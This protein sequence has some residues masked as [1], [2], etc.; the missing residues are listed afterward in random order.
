MKLSVKTWF[1]ISS[2]VI[3]MGILLTLGFLVGKRS[4]K[5]VS[6]ST[7]YVTDTVYLDKPF[8][9]PV[10]PKGFKYTVKPTIALYQKPFD[11]RLSELKRLNDSLQMV[12]SNTSG[13]I[14]TVV[15]SDKFLT[16]FPTSPKLLSM[17][18][19]YDSLW[20]SVLNTQAKVV[21]LHYPLDLTHNTYWFGDYTLTSKPFNPPKTKVPL[22]PSLALYTGL[23]LPIDGT[24]SPLLS[25]QYTQPIRPVQL[26]LEAQM[27]INNKPQYIIFAK[28]GFRIF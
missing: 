18:L 23:Q 4:V 8:P 12:I 3:L 24:I 9:K 6:G 10:N 13:H 22:K 27:T 28:A 15:V 14:D 17:S 1:K 21:T 16:L 11:N 26:Q 5:P 19:R 20:L 2:V 25:A 7:N